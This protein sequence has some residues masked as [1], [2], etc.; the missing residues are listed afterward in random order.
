MLK[1]KKEFIID[2]NNLISNIKKDNLSNYLANASPTLN[3]QE[4]ISFLYQSII[5]EQLPK[6]SKK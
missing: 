2:Y 5:K 6:K 3:K 4:T 1:V